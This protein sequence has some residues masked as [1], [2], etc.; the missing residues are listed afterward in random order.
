MRVKKR[1]RRINQ[2]KPWVEFIRDVG[3][4]LGIPILIGV[5]VQ[6]YTQQ[7][8]IL[9]ARTEL[10]KETQ[11][12]RALSVIKSQKEIY[13]LERQSLDKSIKKLE[14]TISKS[15]ETLSD[16]EKEIAILRTR[17][18]KVIETI[19]SLE[20]STYV[21]KLASQQ[22]GI[23]QDALKGFMR[24]VEEERVPTEQIESVLQEHASDFKRTQTVKFLMT[25]AH[26]HWARGDLKQAEL[27]YQAALFVLEKIPNDRFHEQLVQALKEYADFLHLL[28]RHEEAERLEMQVK[29]IQQREM[30]K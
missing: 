2:I 8:E 25:S 3:L 14:G 20:A 30:S 21:I 17:L 1:V 9:K 28:Q 16:K 22:L 15:T 12:D 7:I 26:S 24:M 29:S 13:E 23:T 19:G 6:L 27:V 10:L 4:I 5:G 11:Y 18:T